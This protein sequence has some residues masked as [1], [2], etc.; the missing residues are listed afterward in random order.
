MVTD[1]DDETGLGNSEAEVEV[2]GRHSTSLLL[3]ASTLLKVRGI[4]EPTKGVGKVK[5]SGTFS[6][7]FSFGVSSEASSVFKMDRTTTKSQVS[8]QRKHNVSI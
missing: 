3:L 8:K 1:E 2:V 7:C 6:A 4:A 5:S